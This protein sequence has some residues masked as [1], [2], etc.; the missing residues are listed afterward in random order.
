MSGDSVI[1]SVARNRA[2]V[3][4][5]HG[6]STAPKHEPP[7]LLVCLP[8]RATRAP[9]LGIVIMMPASVVLPREIAQLSLDAGEFVQSPLLI[10]PIFR[11][12]LGRVP[13]RDCWMLST[14]FW[15]AAGFRTPG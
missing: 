1:S 14:A 6:A 11:P 3:G 13:R 15:P 4:L 9:T 7:G 5:R 8:V 10:G 2:P 12:K